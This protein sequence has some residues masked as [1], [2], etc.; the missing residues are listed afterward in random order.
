L[1][2]QMWLPAL[3]SIARFAVFTLDD[4]TENDDNCA[5]IYHK[6]LLY[7]VSNAF[8]DTVRI[9]LLHPDG[10]PILG[11]QKFINADGALKRLFGPSGAADWVIAPNT[12]TSGTLG[13]STAKCHGDF[14]DD[15]ATV[16]ST[17]ARVLDRKTKAAPSLSFERSGQGNRAV[18]RKIDQMQ[19]HAL[20]R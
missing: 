3:K 18:R 5:N 6:S 11:M 16:L 13:A 17:L 4:K 12:E 8:E 14:D 1:F 10:E 7:L 20:T 2:K 19:D 9:P 15:K